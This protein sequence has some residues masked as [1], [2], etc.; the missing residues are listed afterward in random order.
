MTIQVDGKPVEAYHLIMKKEN[1][2]DILN[3]KK[4]VEIR[5]FSDKYL[6]MFIDQEKYKEYQEKLKEPD[7]QGVDENGVLE[8]DKTIRTDIKHIYFTNYNKTWSLVVKIHSFYTLSMIK[9]DIAFLAEN[10]DF[11]DYDNE[12]Q[13]FEGKELD[14]VP[15]FFA[16]YLDKVISHEGL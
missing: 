1:A 11:H 14:E 8:F 15:A 9:D 10:F 7:F 4:K 3:G 12:W 13:Q 6:S 5:T 16:I 2:L